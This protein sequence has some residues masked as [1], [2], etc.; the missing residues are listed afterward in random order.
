[1]DYIPQLAIFFLGCSAIWVIGRREEWNRW[2]Y[3]LGLCSQPFWLW[4]SIINEQWGI[5]VLSLWYAYSWGQGVYNYW[6]INEQGGTTRIKN[7]AEKEIINTLQQSNNEGTDSPYWLILDPA[8]NMACDIGILANQ[9]TGPFF[10]REDAEDHLQSRRYAFSKKACV[11][12]HSGYWS[13][14]HKSLCDHLQRSRY[15]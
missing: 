12:C 10:C 6:I 14:K 7:K 2:G 13:I 15:T 11:Y 3:I 4:T 5:A 8:Q 1:M 9:I